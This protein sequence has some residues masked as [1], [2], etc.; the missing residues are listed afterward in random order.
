MDTE[1]FE[2]TFGKK[3]TRKRPNLKISDMQVTNIY[4]VQLV[5]NLMSVAS[6]FSFSHSVFFT[7]SEN[8][9]QFSSKLKLLSANLKISDMQV[10]N[11]YTVQLVYNLM[12]VGKI[13]YF[14][15][16]GF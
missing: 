5:Y 1:P 3:K 12:S 15:C 2:A 13:Y 10:T 8:F 11:I 6:N 7:G 14:F 16:I 4:T 9:P